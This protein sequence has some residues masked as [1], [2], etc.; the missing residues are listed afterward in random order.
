M[1]DLIDD[2]MIRYGVGYTPSVPPEVV[3]YYLKK[4]LELKCQHSPFHYIEVGMGQRKEL[5]GNS[6]KDSDN[7]RY[8]PYCKVKLSDKVI[9]SEFGKFRVCEKCGRELLDD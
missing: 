4:D 6:I 8:C 3:I 2:D 5:I 7:N 1:D 9:I